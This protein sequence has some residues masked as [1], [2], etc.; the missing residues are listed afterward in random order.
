M[1]RMTLGAGYQAA[2]LVETTPIALARVRKFCTEMAP[3]ARQ[4]FDEFV[5]ASYQRPLLRVLSREKTRQQCQQFLNSL[6]LWLSQ[7]SS[8]DFVEPLPT[9]LRLTE[10][11]ETR[12]PLD[13]VTLSID[14]R[15]ASEW[16]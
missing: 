14:T 16:V 3:S 15:P 2:A 1:V 8:G 9:I 5:A 10:I 13:R 7:S 6:Q 12:I 4:T 11:V